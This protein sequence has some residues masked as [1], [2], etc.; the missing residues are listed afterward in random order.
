MLHTQVLCIS[1]DKTPKEILHVL[2]GAV[3]KLQELCVCFFQQFMLCL[4]LLKII[5][6]TERVPGGMRGACGGAMPH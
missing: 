3:C 5:T 6:E 4:Y 2:R 1:N